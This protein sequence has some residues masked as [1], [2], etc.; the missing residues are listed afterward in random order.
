MLV[1]FLLAETR[2]AGRYFVAAKGGGDKFPQCMA[3]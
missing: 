1:T 2:V 3:G